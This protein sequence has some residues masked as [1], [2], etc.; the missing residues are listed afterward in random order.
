MYKQNV[1]K[2]VQVSDIAID[3]TTDLMK[4]DDLK[5]RISIFQGFCRKPL[6]ILCLI[7][8]PGCTKP[9]DEE[10]YMNMANIMAVKS[11][12]IS[13]QVGAVIIGP[14]GYMVGSGWND[15]GEAK[16]SCGLR[17]IRDLRCEEFMPHVKALL[18]GK[19]T[20][21]ELVKKLE[22]RYPAKVE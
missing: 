1:T 15:V 9:N 14:K 6:R 16:I 12:C 4:T 20:V 13:R 17:E 5:E 2:C 21:D 11:N 8:S 18:A 10:M 22:Q 7:L 19:E 3:N